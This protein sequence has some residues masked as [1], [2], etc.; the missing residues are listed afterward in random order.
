M[1]TLFS[2]ELLSRLGQR[3]KEIAEGKGITIKQLQKLRFE[4]KRL[5]KGV[6]MQ[7]AQTTS[8]CGGSR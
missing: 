4:L 1:K 5:A 7:G 8:K 3:E 2:G 6:R